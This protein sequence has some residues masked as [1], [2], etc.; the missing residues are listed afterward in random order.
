MPGLPAIRKPVNPYV[1]A[2]LTRSSL[3]AR[4]LMDGNQDIFV[5]QIR[6]DLRHLRFG[7]PLRLLQS[8][9]DRRRIH[10]QRL[11][12]QGE[13]DANARIRKCRRVVFNSIAP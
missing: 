9:P 3:L 5:W 10:A 13:Q 1:G 2:K 12:S 7:H 4:V 11:L 6:V 8:S